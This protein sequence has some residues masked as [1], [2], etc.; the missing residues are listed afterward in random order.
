MMNLPSRWYPV[1]GIV[2][3]RSDPAVIKVFLHGTIPMEK[4]E[5]ASLESPVAGRN[6]DITVIPGHF[7]DRFKWRRLGDG[8]FPY[9]GEMVMVYLKNGSVVKATPRQ[10]ADV[11][12]FYVDESTVI[13]T[14]DI[15]AWRS[16][17]PGIDQPSP[18]PVHMSSLIYRPQRGGLGES[19]L[20]S[21]EIKTRRDLLEHLQKTWSGKLHPDIALRDSDIEVKLYSDSPDHR[22]DWQRTYIVMVFGSPEGFINGDPP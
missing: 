6:S 1:N 12:V 18:P 13:L 22:I 19:M 7:A 5:Q 9:L 4:L 10:T 11:L 14:G 17:I 8:R 15:V 2:T 16:F 20:E 3:E 21:V